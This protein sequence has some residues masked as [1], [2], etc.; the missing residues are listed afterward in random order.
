[1]AVVPDMA[2]VHEVAAVADPRD[3]R[4]PHRAGIHGDAFAD[5]AAGADHEPGQLALVAQRLRWG[6]ERGERIDRAI[7]RRCVVCAVTLTCAISLVRRRSRHAGRS[8]KRDRSRPLADHG[9][10]LDP[11][12]R[13][14]R[15]HQQPSP[16]IGRDIPRFQVVSAT[17]QRCPVTYGYAVCRRVGAIWHGDDGVR[18]ARRS[19]DEFNPSASRRRRPP[20]P[21][22]H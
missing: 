18:R 1:M 19:I 2:A 20:R 8:C 16:S 5:R 17:Y 14:D 3:A 22:C 10:I 21:R 7:R 9:A 13:I 11:R 6:A 4:R 12:G 15:T